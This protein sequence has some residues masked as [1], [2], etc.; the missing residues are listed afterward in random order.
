MKLMSNVQSSTKSLLPL[1][2]PIA[3]N[4]YVTKKI[5]DS[6]QKHT[7]IRNLTDCEL[8]S[9][10]WIKQSSDAKQLGVY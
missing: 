6:L 1:L 3:C 7:D 4:S 9:W 10:K 2:Y 5:I 8:R